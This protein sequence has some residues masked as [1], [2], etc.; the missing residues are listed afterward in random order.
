MRRVRVAAPD[1]VWF[2]S[3][4]EA[5]EG[6]VTWQTDRHGVFELVAPAGREAEL[7]DLLRDLAREGSLEL[8]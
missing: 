8:V 1:H 5:Y 3:I 6:L 2:R 4:L 7:D